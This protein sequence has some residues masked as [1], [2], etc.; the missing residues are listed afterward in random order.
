MIDGQPIGDQVGIT[1]SNSLNPGVAEG[2]EIVTGGIPAEYGEKANGVI[3]LTT[4]S[5][6]GTNG[7]KGDVSVGRGAASRQASA[8]VAAG[9][10]DSRFGWFASVDGSRS[11]RFLDPVSF[12]NSPQRRE[13]GPRLPAAGLGL[14][15][16]GRA[17][18]A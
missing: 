8:S 2:I 1:F 12:D 13:H 6:L 18:G 3:N 5:G 14:G 7:V 16:T 9:G 17:T 10:G 4:R 15:E 11:D